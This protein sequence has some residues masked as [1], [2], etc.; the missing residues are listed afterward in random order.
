MPA[1]AVYTA[2][3]RM[4]CVRLVVSTDMPLGASI[5]S[6]V[7][8]CLTGKRRN[9]PYF[10]GHV[11]PGEGRHRI[12]ASAVLS[13]LTKNK[14]NF[15]I[16]WFETTVDPPDTFGKMSD[17]LGC[18]SYP[19][20]EGEMQ[21]SAVFSYDKTKVDSVFKPIQL[22]GQPAIFDE[23]TGFTGIKRDPQGK[24][25]L[26]EIEVS[27]GTNRLSHTVR[28]TQG[29]RLSED[30]PLQLLDTANKISSLAL[31]PKEGAEK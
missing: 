18:L 5:I 3:K 29:I 26:Y 1:S 24:K 14:F 13:R 31:L 20:G 9:L 17:L 8:D 16:Q 22:A 10:F 11:Y 30:L 4:N 21:V 12:G 7:R 27:H 15:W 23:L 19:W 2:F 6:K 25:L 28:F